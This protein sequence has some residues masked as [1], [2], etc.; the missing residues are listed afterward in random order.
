MASANHIRSAL[1]ELSALER[2]EALAELVGDLQAQLAALQERV[3]AA[4][5]SGCPKCKKFAFRLVESHPTP[6]AVGALHVRA[7]VYR[8]AACSHEDV[9]QVSALGSPKPTSVPVD[10]APRFTLDARAITQ[11]EVRV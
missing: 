10:T 2:I 5:G 6:R 9:H 1:D 3:E 8:C 11:L 4:T 7:W